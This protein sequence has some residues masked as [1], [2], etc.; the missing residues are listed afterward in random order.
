M[1]CAKAV[2]ALVRY[3]VFQLFILALHHQDRPKSFIE[4]GYRFV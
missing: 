1:G 3:N 4:A 2:K